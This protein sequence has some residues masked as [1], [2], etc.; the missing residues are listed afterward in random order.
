MTLPPLQSV[1]ESLLEETLSSDGSV[2]LL[3]AATVRR[4]ADTVKPSV[5]LEQLQAY[6][7]F[8]DNKTL[9]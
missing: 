5:T 8:A 7:R 9:P 1:F 6:R 4:C 3:R 2:P